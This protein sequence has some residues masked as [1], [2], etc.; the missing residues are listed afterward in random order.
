MVRLSVVLLLSVPLLASACDS[1]QATATGAAPAQPAAEP[2]TPTP[3]APAAQPAPP[4]AAAPAD[5]APAEAADNEPGA[6][7][8]VD[9]GSLAGHY[10]FGWSG[11]KTAK[12]RK[13]DAKMIKKLSGKD[14]TC[15]QSET[16]AAFAEGAGVWSTCEVGESKWA[17][18]A[19]KAICQEQL[20]TMEANAP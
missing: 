6:G 17:V 13:V 5:A 10:A 9:P 11:G 20:E 2:T 3:V 15:R 12:C 18:F 4:A 16:S 1:K 8:P 19:T 7:A 14:A